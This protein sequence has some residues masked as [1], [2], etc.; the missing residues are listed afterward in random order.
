LEETMANHETRAEKAHHEQEAP[1]AKKGPEI[2]DI[3]LT[4]KLLTIASASANNA[5]LRAVYAAAQHQLNK[6]NATI[7]E[8]IDKV[9]KA[10]AEAISKK[11]AEDAEAARQ[12]KRKAEDE[13]LEASRKAEADAKK[14]EARPSA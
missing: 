1:A 5:G 12:A 7:Q 2:V 8:G 4:A 13:A 14:A 10:E 6:I 3:D 9:R 11:E